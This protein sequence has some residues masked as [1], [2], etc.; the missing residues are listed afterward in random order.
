MKILLSLI[1]PLLALTAWTYHFKKE[2]STLQK[3]AAKLD[4]IERLSYHYYLEIND[5][6]ENYFDKDSSDCYFEFNQKSKFVS[7]FKAEN[8][9]SIQ[10]FNGSEK[11]T[12]DKKEKTYEI[13]DKNS[14]KSFSSL[15]IMANAIPVLKRCLDDVIAN[16]S[17]AKTER[18]TVLAGRN[19]KVVTL[20]LQSKGL[21]YF[22]KFRSFTAK[23]TMF[24]DLI[25]DPATY[26]PYQVIQRNS[27]AGKDYSMRVAFTHINLS[28]VVPKQN[29]WFYSSYEKDYKRAKKKE[30]IPLIT[31]GSTLPT[32]A[33]PQMGNQTAAPVTPAIKNKIVLFDFWIKNCGY[34][35]ESFPH[36]KDLQVKYGKRNVEIITVNAH[37]SYQEID[38]FYKREKPTYQ[39][40]YQGQAL[41]KKLGVKD[42]GYPTVILADTNGKIVYTG[43][44]DKEKIEQIIE[45]LL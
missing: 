20:S 35:M 36:L 42:R 8:N 10:I 3:V 7:R 23:M 26:L 32:I 44:F 43:S 28:P 25:I 39:M 24:Y 19:Y 14:Q 29:T 37:D 15:I 18:D 34:C 4:G 33:L 9:E 40:L 27:I 13:D 11:F 45:K 41:A 2:P 17:V 30:A 12:L 22:S 16:D 1:T 21:D 5:A 38:F 31:V 6:K